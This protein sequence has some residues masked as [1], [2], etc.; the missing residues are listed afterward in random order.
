MKERV[1]IIATK[2]HARIRIPANSDPVTTTAD[3]VEI[4]NLNVEIRTA[5]IPPTKR[6]IKSL[7]FGDARKAPKPKAE[8]HGVT[9]NSTMIRV[10]T[11]TAVLVIV[12]IPAEVL[13]VNA[14]TTVVR[15]IHVTRTKTEPAAV[16]EGSIRAAKAAVPENGVIKHQTTNS[17]V[18]GL[19]E[20]V[21]LEVD[22][23]K[24][25][26]ISAVA[27]LDEKM[28]SVIDLAE[29][30]DLTMADL[31]TDLREGM[32]DSMIDLLE[33]IIV[34]MMADLVTITAGIIRKPIVG[35]IRPRRTI[36]GTTNLR[37]TIAGTISPK[38]T[39]VGIT[40][41][42]IITHGTIKKKPT[43]PVGDLIK[44]IAVVD[45][46]S[47]MIVAVVSAT[48][49]VEEETA[50]LENG[51]ITSV[52]TEALKSGVT[53]S[54]LGKLSLKIFISYFSLIIM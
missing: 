40:K 22:V 30:T 32:A 28:G 12:T 11:D 8:N 14:T 38:Q 1:R 5:S 39:I 52:L 19:N 10:T 2:G 24:A 49:I 43:I 26:M 23:K 46:I 45:V 47:A 6:G 20:M 16:N 35:I 9:T 51:T 50:D 44:I 37:R 31:K 21:A 7:I 33:E 53:I 54:D 13:I 29:I 18:E 36:V 42:T 48:I 41:P 4:T 25:G 15:G 17:A 34:P 27:R 3:E